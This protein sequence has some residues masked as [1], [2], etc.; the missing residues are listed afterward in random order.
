MTIATFGEEFGENLV[1]GKLVA[2]PTALA[3]R[4]QVF[5]RRGW[6]KQVPEAFAATLLSLCEER[7]FGAGE[8]ICEIGDAGGS[9]FGVLE[10]SVGCWIASAY[11]E[12][13]L[14][15]VAREGDWFGEGPAVQGGFRTMSFRALEP[16]LLMRL[17]PSALKLL[18]ELEPETSRWLGL[19]SERAAQVA[20]RAV[21]DLL[22]P[23]SERRLVAVLLRVTGV[24]DGISPADSDGFRLSQSEIAE[25][26]GFSRNHANRILQRLQ[27]RGLVE[28]RYQRL[29]IPD[30][31]RLAALARGE[32]AGDAAAA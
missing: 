5:S 6:L 9:I 31:E 14:A 1:A 20:I 18:A 24:E 15:H 22:I 29:A 10:G 2:R 27:L 3:H 13:A 30:P 4:Q 17:E 32:R 25:M 28:L 19:Q 23:D 12:V 21:S 26:A 11:A 8:S 16:S 7:R